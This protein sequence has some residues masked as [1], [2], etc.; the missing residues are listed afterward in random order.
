MKSNALAK[1]LE[2]YA[3]ASPLPN[4]PE[5]WSALASLFA[6]AKTK[7]VADF[8][9]DL[10]SLAVDPQ[11]QTR[12]IGELLP[13]IHAMQATAIALGKA[14]FA[15]ALEPLKDFIRQHPSVAVERIQTT[16]A[17]RVQSQSAR[18]G[19]GRRQPASKDPTI[20]PSY[21]KRLE[22]ALGDERGF[23]EVMAAIEADQQLKAYHF[24][25]LAKV[26]TGQAGRNK[27]DALEI[28]KAR[29]LNLL[30]A[31]EK[32]KFNAGQTAA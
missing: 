27:K 22:E 24:K 8:V 5:D 12:G 30:D 31:R 16:L 28:I 10:R 29:H 20:V 23:E 18:G 6:S 26:F 3:K 32:G 7:E 4:S 13:E 1:I 25:E 19:S 11:T 2:S 9:R 15:D 14:P 17:Q 21:I